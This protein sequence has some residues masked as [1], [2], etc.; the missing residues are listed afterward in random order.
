MAFHP[1]RLLQLPNVFHPNTAQ[2][3]KDNFLLLRLSKH[4]PFEKTVGKKM[5]YGVSIREAGAGP[6]TCALSEGVPAAG[7]ACLE[8][9]LNCRVHDYRQ[10]L[11]ACVPSCAP[12]SSE[13]L[14]KLLF[15]NTNRPCARQSRKPNQNQKAFC[16]TSSPCG[17]INPRTTRYGC[18]FLHLGAQQRKQKRGLNHRTEQRTEARSS[19]MGE[20]T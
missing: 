15:T 10:P 14:V 4:A 7:C 17:E 3:R 1:T 11:R 9:C 13:K 16:R 12:L 18:L 2:H 20:K 19:H 5:G 8:R 6:N